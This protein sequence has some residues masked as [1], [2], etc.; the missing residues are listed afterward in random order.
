M[1]FL[2]LGAVYPLAYPASGFWLRRRKLCHHSCIRHSPAQLPWNR[3]SITPAPTTVNLT[4]V[5]SLTAGTKPT[6][7][8]LHLHL[9]VRRRRRLAYATRALDFIGLTTSAAG[10][11]T[12]DMTDLI[13]ASATGLSMRPQ[14]PTVSCMPAGGIRRTTLLRWAF[15]SSF[16]I[17]MD[18]SPH[19]VT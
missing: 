12:T 5:S 14:M 11:L 13:T 19:M 1:V 3:F 7:I 8:A 2:S 18:I 16:I 9:Q 6:R 4:T 10:W 15:T 17:Q